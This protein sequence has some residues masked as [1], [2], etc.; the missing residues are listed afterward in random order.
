MREERKG[1]EERKKEKKE[2][3]EQTGAVRQVGFRV[4]HTCCPQVSLD[5]T[6]P[7]SESSH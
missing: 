3:S 2:K 7:S 5:S 4:F 1:K 6:L